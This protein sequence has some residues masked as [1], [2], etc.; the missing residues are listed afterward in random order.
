MLD[1][2]TKKVYKHSFSLVSHCRKSYIFSNFLQG[3]FPTSHVLR[4]PRA[5]D[6]WFQPFRKKGS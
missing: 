6:A 3:I 1:F 5:Q 4:K 2:L